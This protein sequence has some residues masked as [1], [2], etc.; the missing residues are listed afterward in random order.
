VD[1]ATA[2]AIPA[3]LGVLLVEDNDAVAEVAAAMLEELGCVV[4]RASSA[5]EAL[6]RLQTGAL[7]GL[8]LS[9]IVMPG[10][11]DGLELAR[12][13]RQLHPGLPVLLSTGY[14]S[15]AQEAAAEGI[16]LLA[17]PYAPAQLEPAIALALSGRTGDEPLGRAA[18]AGQ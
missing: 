1:G 7:P 16:A 18:Q 9:D 11:M 8:V 17:K 2:A 15:A 6:R 13:I 14:S 4:G 10:G 5:R 12:A 3:A